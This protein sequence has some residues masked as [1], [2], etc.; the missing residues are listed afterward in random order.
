MEKTDPVSTKVDVAYYISMALKRELSWNAL[1]IFFDGFKLTNEQYK[2][3]VKLLL[4]ELEQLQV[5]LLSKENTLLEPENQINI[6][7]II[8]IPFV[9][10]LFSNLSSSS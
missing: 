5:Q 4:K 10:P 9:S 1:A 7:E 6:P 2:N 3:V 8:R